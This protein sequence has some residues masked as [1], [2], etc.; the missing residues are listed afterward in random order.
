MQKWKWRTEALACRGCH[1]TLC[2]EASVP[3]QAAP[4]QPWRGSRWPLGHYQADVPP[5]EQGGALQCHRNKSQ[6]MRRERAHRP[7]QPL[8]PGSVSLQSV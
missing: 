4:F 3:A 5:L 8:V 1:T 7:P 2:L 6:Q